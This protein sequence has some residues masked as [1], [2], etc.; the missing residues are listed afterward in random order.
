VVPGAE[1]ALNG[2]NDAELRALND[3][4]FQGVVRPLLAQTHQFTPPVQFIGVVQP[5]TNTAIVQKPFVK[6][7]P[8]EEAG[9]ARRGL[10]GAK[11][12]ELVDSAC[13]A[14]EPPVEETTEE[15]LP[16]MRWTEKWKQTALESEGT[17]VM[18]KQDPPKQPKQP[19]LTEMAK[20]KG[21]T[22]AAH[23]PTPFK[24]RFKVNI[25][26][27]SAHQMNFYRPIS[28]QRSNDKRNIS[29][30]SMFSQTSIPLRSPS[31]SPTVVTSLPVD[32]SCQTSPPKPA[33]AALVD[34]IWEAPKPAIVPATTDNPSRESL[35]SILDE[36]PTFP[37]TETTGSFP[38]K[39]V[40]T[41]PPL[42]NLSTAPTT[43]TSALLP[44][45]TT[46]PNFTTSTG[47]VHGNIC[48]EWNYY[49]SCSPSKYPTC[50]RLHIC[51]ICSSPEHRSTQHWHHLAT[52]PLPEIQSQP[53]LSSFAPPPESPTLSALRE[54]R[55]PP[56]VSPPRPNDG[57]AQEGAMYGLP[58]IPLFV[59]SFG[60]GTA[61]PTSPDR[62]KPRKRPCRIVAPTSP[63]STEKPPSVNPSPVVSVQTPQIPPPPYPFENPLEVI[64][65]PPVKPFQRKPP[66]VEPPAP[67]PVTPQPVSTPGGLRVTAPAFEPSPSSSAQLGSWVPFMGSNPQ[68]N[69]LFKIPSRQSRRIA[70]I[71]PADKQKKPE[72]SPTPSPEPPESKGGVEKEQVEEE[73]PSPASDVAKRAM[74]MRGGS[75]SISSSAR[76]STSKASLVIK[77]RMETPTAMTACIEKTNSGIWAGAI[78]IYTVATHDYLKDHF[79]FYTKRWPPLHGPSDCPPPA[80]KAGWSDGCSAAVGSGMDRSVIA[81][82]DE[83]LEGL[84]GKASE[85]EVAKTLETIFEICS[86]PS[87]SS[88]TTPKQWSFPPHLPPTSPTTTVMP[89]NPPAT[90][91]LVPLPTPVPVASTATPTSTFVTLDDF[92]DDVESVLRRLTAAENQPPTTEVR[93][94]S[95]DSSSTAPLSPCGSPHSARAIDRPPQTATLNPGSRR[96]QMLSCAATRGEGPC[97]CGLG[98]WFDHRPRS[99]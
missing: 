21:P 23:V 93:P 81:M 64:L 45:P 3:R 16:G 76:G 15:K 1:P 59:P 18:I 71:A 39:P 8:G 38:F 11:E 36:P 32:K 7:P 37:F 40:I 67:E 10:Q 84:L 92:T 86:T 54:L 56:R 88:A 44:S 65:P 48:Y 55:A 31:M 79:P 77:K 53:K 98:D 2:Y 22:A 60:L 30:P 51:E 69:D 47:S 29:Y 62:L 28:R 25:P 12:V 6:L 97:D 82:I 42:I 68:F 46:I 19:K 95:S 13:T 27:P 17:V 87:S 85:E 94:R 61:P 57:N 20:A 5:I 83:E 4:A 43:P 50:Q 96:E 24:G 52:A 49:M 63:P 34:I 66:P 14:S 73:G 78:P 72:R 75:G 58:P 35:T 91:A 89:T 26:R 90:L 33:S 41:T 9:D 74:H 99:T 80:K 70:I